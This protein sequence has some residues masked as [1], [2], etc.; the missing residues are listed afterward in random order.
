MVNVREPRRNSVVPLV[1]VAIMAPVVKA[2]ATKGGDIEAL[3][4]PHG[5]SARC[6]DSA[7]T[8]ATNDTIYAVFN[9]VAE[10]TSSDF[11]A[12]VGQNLNSA[13]FQ[14]IAPKVGGAATLG[15]ILTTFTV[16][17]A[18]EANAVSMSVL[19]EDG[20]TYFTAKRKF[21]PS[22]SPAQVDA[23]QVA[24]WMGLLH[25]VMDFRWDPSQIVLRVNKPSAIP[26][27]F[28]G[29][30]PI[31]C[32]STGFSFRFPAEWML[33]K[34]SFDHLVAPTSRAL[35]L[36]TPAPVNLIAS[37]K[38]V[39]RPRLAE[40]GFGVDEAAKACGVKADTLNR[41]L[42]SY[43]TTISA[44]LTDL[45]REEAETALTAGTQSVADIAQRLGYSDATAFTR[46]F[47]KWTGHTP[48]SFRS[49]KPKWR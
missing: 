36:D 13:M 37:I 12:R 10:Q 28:H 26:S 43:S 17:V 48:S 9:E 6:L 31:A 45:R 11:C 21:A 18:R 2:F 32:D 8:F 44:V 23:F 29:I 20:H 47:K 3:L 41:R 25:R 19:V 22:V 39:I 49:A 46:A 35:D 33:Q 24:M 40:P 4:S 38:D 30:R 42:R 14:M 5:L 7:E 15:D 1:R 16:E 34:I 27:E